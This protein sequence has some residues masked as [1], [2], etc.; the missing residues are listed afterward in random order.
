[1]ICV[2]KLIFVMYTVGT[3]CSSLGFVLDQWGVSW[4]LFQCEWG[5]FTTNLVTVQGLCE[6]LCYEYIRAYFLVLSSHGRSWL[7][8]SVQLRATTICCVKLYPAVTGSLQC[9]CVFA[10]A[11]VCARSSLIPFRCNICLA[12]GS[13][14]T[15]CFFLL[16]NFFFFFFLHSLISDPTGWWALNTICEK[17]ESLL[18]FLHPSLAFLFSYPSHYLMHTHFLEFVSDFINVW[19][20]TDDSEVDRHMW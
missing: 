2:H 6:L 10:C 8:T 11:Y 20:D 9:V 15:S 4:F 19:H 17:T 13:M 1:M 18:L 5:P 12:S 7:A 14:M 3:G 16:F